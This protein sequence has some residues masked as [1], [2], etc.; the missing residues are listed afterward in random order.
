MINRSGNTSSKKEKE[1]M[2]RKKINYAVDIHRKA[3]ELVIAGQ[4]TSTHT[5]YDTN[6]R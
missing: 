5:T 4:Y 2:I 1:I 6:N 3:M